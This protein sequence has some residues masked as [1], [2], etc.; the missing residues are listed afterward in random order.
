[1]FSLS[2]SSILCFIATIADVYP[3]SHFCILTLTLSLSLSL[4][5]SIFP[6]LMNFLR[7]VCLFKHFHNEM[8]TRRLSFKTFLQWYAGAYPRGA[9]LLP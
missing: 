5:F 6:F 9:T 3:L 8:K 4:R 2:L 7:I 1:L